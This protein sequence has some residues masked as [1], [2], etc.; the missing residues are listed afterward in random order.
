MTPD[1]KALCDRLRG[2]DPIP[3]RSD[4]ADAIEAIVARLT[5]ERDA[6]QAVTVEQCA[7]YHDRHADGYAKTRSRLDEAAHRQHAAA[8]RAIAQDNTP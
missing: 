3:S 1:H 4:V 6:V 5:A 7:Q 2:Q 8:I